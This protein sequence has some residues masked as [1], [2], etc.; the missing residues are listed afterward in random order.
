MTLLGFNYCYASACC[1]YPLRVGSKAREILSVPPKSAVSVVGVLPRVRFANGRSFRANRSGFRRSVAHDVRLLRG[2]LASVCAPS[3]R[4]GLQIE[5]P[6]PAPEHAECYSDMFHAPVF[7]GRPQASVVLPAR[8][9]ALESPFA[10]HALQHAALSH[11]H[12]SARR[13]HGDRLLVARVEQL[14]AQ[15]GARLG[16]TQAARLLWVPIV[17]SAVGS[18][19]RARAI[20][21]CLTKACST[22]R[23][24]CSWITI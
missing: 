2:D 24:A 3:L 6:N 15:R 22:K 19:A 17:P 14:L 18:A 13:L 11:V 23:S 12:Q 16:L 5:L 7:F 8:W 9:L 1:P 10:D 4:H 20:R 21:L